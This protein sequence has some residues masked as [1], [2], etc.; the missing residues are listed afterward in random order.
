MQNSRTKPFKKIII[1]ATISGTAGRDYLS[2][3]FKFAGKGKK[4]TI[5]V[6]DNPAML[7]KRIRQSE[8]P[9]GIIIML[10]HENPTLV[11]LQRRNIPTVVV[12]FPPRGFA[13]IRGSLSF[14]RLNDAVIGETAAQH[15][16]DQG[17]FN[18]FLC[19]IDQPQ[20][21]YSRVRENAFRERLKNTGRFIKTVLISDIQAAERSQRALLLTLKRLPRP[22]G[23]F[24]TRDRAASRVYDA[25]RDL[26][27]FIPD[28]VAI[29]GV[30]NDELFCNTAA[31]PL[32]SILPDH[33]QVGYLAA[34][35]LN[36]LLHG[37][38]GKETVFHKSVREVVLRASTR[39][40]PPT[41]RIVA[42]ALTFIE[43]NASGTLSVADVVEHIGI[44][45]RLAD[46]RFR[47]IR[48]ET[49]L[50]AIVRARI[51]R[52]K[53]CLLTSNDSMSRIAA[54]CDFSSAAVFS[55]F[56]KTHV[57]ETPQGWRLKRH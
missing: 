12:D 48:N 30:D 57:G 49:I 39:I 13:A 23:V 1:A 15:L 55:R 56:F 21:A 24:V 10:P 44:S 33:T 47:Q 9:D 31:V 6:L 19:A 40:I 35:E 8:G 34:K 27:F 36:R 2:G 3:V 32:S 22:V 53:K 26:G 54:D 5:E 17:N 38:T 41:A 28:E 14:V 16:L 51:R 7:D 20:F 29:I 52:I 45:R 50:D 37:G 4:W 42:D 11:S 43:D 46:L 18:S 25:C